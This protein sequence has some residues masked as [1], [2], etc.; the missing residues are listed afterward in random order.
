LNGELVDWTVPGYM[1]YMGHDTFTRQWVKQQTYGGKLDENADSAFSRD[2]LCHA[3]LAL[4]AAGYGIVG[5]EHDKPILEVPEG[6]QVEVDEIKRLMLQQPEYAAG[7]PL[8][9]DGKRSKRYGK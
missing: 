6:G 4:D 2:L 1:E 9:T 8:A 7:L 5:S 3:M